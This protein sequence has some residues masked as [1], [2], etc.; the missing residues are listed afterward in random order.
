MTLDHI[1][2]GRVELGIG[3]GWHVAEHAAYG[4]S[5]DSPKVRSDRLEEGI[6]A[7]RLLFTD[8][9]S[10]FDGEHHQ[11]SDGKLYPRPVQSRIPLVVGGRGE[12]RT[13]RTATRHA[14]GWNVPYINIAVYQY[15]SGVLD[16]WCEREGRDPAELERSVNL[17]MRMGVNADD[18]RRIEQERGTIEGAAAG[19]AQRVIETI[20]TYEQAGAARV[21]VAIR[22]P[23]EWDALRLFAEEVIPALKA[24]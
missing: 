23:V 24:V 10:N 3:A 15:S 5:F 16:Q 18:G 12:Q 2:H 8:E 14:D 6:Q 7:L 20:K 11:L 13:L 1:S 9:V 4:Y 17:H 19:D 22:P 21:S